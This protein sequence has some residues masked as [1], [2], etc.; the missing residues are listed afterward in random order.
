[1]NKLLKWFNKNQRDFPWR[2]PDRN[3]YEVLVAEVMLQRTTST[4]VG[5]IYTPFLEN[6]PKPSSLAK[7]DESELKEIIAPLGLQDQR[8]KHFL[9]IGRKLVNE[10]K[11]EIPRDY[12]NL[13][14][15]PGVGNYISNAVLCFA[16]NEDVPILDTNVSRVLARAFYGND[17]ALP[18]EKKDSWTFAADLVPRGRGRDFGY[19]LLDLGNQVCRAL[20][21]KHDLCPVASVCEFYSEESPRS[22]IESNS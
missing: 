13:S 2:D 18:P 9:R 8:S 4:K 11:G 16:Y 20:R 6:Y 15:L 14:S 3:P 21:P 12:E 17:D 19:A 5:E 22:T 10:M 1:M 7:A